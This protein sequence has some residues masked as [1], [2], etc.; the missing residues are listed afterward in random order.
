MPGYLEVHAKRAAE[1]SGRKRKEMQ[2]KRERELISVRGGTGERDWESTGEST[3][4]REWVYLGFRVGFVGFIQ[5]GW[6]LVGFLFVSGFSWMEL[7]MEVA[8]IGSVPRPRCMETS[9][10]M[11]RRQ[12]GLTALT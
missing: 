10:S 2:R 11:G 5:V 6:G 12:K 4:Y 8:G 3:D 9:Q 7:L 1:V